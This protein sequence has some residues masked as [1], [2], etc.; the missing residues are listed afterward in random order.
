MREAP[1]PLET[2]LS[3]LRPQEVSPGLR[4]RV[5]ERLA[6]VPP[7]T[8]RRLWW[9]ALVGGLAAACL[10]AVLLWGR[11]GRRDE[12]ER[13]VGPPPAPHAP[14]EEPGPTL[15]S[16]QRALARS[17]EE[18]EALLDKDVPPAPEPDSE[19]VPLGTLTR[20]DAVLHALLGEN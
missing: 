9:F 14:A 11:G 5:A 19:Q 20:S 7:P 4:H 17:P 6:E 13:T 2:E 3:A 16:Y 8:R 12:P 1:D 15:L 18:L 10:A